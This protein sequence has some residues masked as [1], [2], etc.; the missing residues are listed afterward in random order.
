MGVR[1]EVVPFIFGAIVF[2]IIIAVVCRLCGITVQRGILS[3]VIPAVVLI[4]YFF[5]FFRD[6][7]R[8][9]PADEA[10]I[11]AGADGVLACIKDVREEKD[12][13]TDTI[14]V[15]I[16]LSLFDVHVNRA[17]ISGKSRFLG[18]FKGKHF[19]TF[20]E[21]S[22]DYNQH[23]AILIEGKTRCLVKQIVG[24]VC[25]R[26]VYWPDHDNPVDLK[27]GDRIGMMKFGSRLDMYFPKSDVEITA[28]VG[29]KVSAGLTG[30]GRIK[31]D[32]NK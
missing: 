18:Y 23:N 3:G 30:I 5:Y 9:P 29:D 25:R 10:L 14:R 20:K 6:P 1:E 17:P 11:L 12:L 8:T 16:F 15:S 19:F 24:P 13:K 7:E 31:G 26:V 22:S 21:K 2:G 28:K 27:K 4:S 32:V